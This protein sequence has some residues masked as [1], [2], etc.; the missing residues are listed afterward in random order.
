MSKTRLDIEFENFITQCA[1]PE[2]KEN[3]VMIEYYRRAFNAGFICMWLMLTVELP[4]I[5]CDKE[6]D[7]YMYNLSKEMDFL[8]KDI[9]IDRGENM[10]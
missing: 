8:T 9:S 3:E 2:L 6:Q 1:T 7:F 4:S 5:E 10:N